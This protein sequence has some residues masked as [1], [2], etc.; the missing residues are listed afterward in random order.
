MKGGEPE[1]VMGA[2]LAE[3][4]PPE[5]RE[6]EYICVPEEEGYKPSRHTISREQRVRFRLAARLRFNV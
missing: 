3:G 4:G 2:F 1:D 5:S 6:A